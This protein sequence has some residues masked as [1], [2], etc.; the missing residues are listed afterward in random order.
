[1]LPFEDEHTRHRQLREIGVDGQNRLAASVAYVATESA[2][3]A[4][5]AELLSRS[6]I[7]VRSVNVA[8]QAKSVCR[9][10]LLSCGLAAAELREGPLSIACGA[11]IAIAHIRETL[12]LP[13]RGPPGLPT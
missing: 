5:A 11:L 10:D 8:S 4:F 13:H 6:G 9:T 3:G 7:P 2:A 1:M 12:E